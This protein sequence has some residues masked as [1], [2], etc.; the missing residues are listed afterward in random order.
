MELVD[1]ILRIDEFLS[2]TLGIVVLF[3]GKRLNKEFGRLVG[4]RLRK[5]GL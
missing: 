3:V 2:V 1:G 4:V 5:L